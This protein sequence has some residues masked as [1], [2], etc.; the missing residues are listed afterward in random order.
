[1]YLLVVISNASFL[2]RR[3]CHGDQQVPRDAK[4]QLGDELEAA[5]GEHL[6]PFRGPLPRLELQISEP[7]LTKTVLKVKAAKIKTYNTG[8]SLVVTDPTTNTAL[9]SVMYAT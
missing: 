6:R 8:Y 1:V 7:T 9:S 2:A 3:R 5:Q 4:Q